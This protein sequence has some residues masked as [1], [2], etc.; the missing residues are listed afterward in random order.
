[1]CANKSMKFA[2]YQYQ[3]LK[4]F[5]VR[6][7]QMQITPYYLLAV[8]VFVL[9]RIKTIFFKYTSSDLDIVKMQNNNK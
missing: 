6:Q 2:S 4:L 3:I 9:E 1:M 5:P 8:V 7:H